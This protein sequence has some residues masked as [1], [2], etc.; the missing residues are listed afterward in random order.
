[1]ELP[2]RVLVKFR[3]NLTRAAELRAAGLYEVKRSIVQDQALRGRQAIEA[4]ALGRDPYRGQRTDATGTVRPD[5]GTPMFT[6]DP[7]GRVNVCL[8]TTIEDLQTIL[9]MVLTQVN[10]LQKPND[11]MAFLVLKLENA[12][13]PVNLSAKQQALIDRLTSRIYG[14]LHGY[15]NPDRSWTLNAAHAEDNP[16]EIRDVRFSTDGSVRCVPRQQHPS[17]HQPPPRG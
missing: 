13:S 12:G 6:W 8:A 3:I 9:G 2:N 14:H 10:T 16:S 5:S 1:M 4:E 11:H 7:K 17:H 15:R